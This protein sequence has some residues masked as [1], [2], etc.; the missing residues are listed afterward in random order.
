ML[1]RLLLARHGRTEWNETGRYQGSSDVGLSSGGLQEAEAL[2]RRLAGERIDAIYCSDLKRAV[3][4]AE[5]VARGRDLKL[6][7]H[8]ELREIDFGGLEGLTFGEIDRRYPGI[9]WW[10][11]RDPDMKLPQ[12]ES[13]SQLAKRVRRFLAELGGH[14]DEETAL[15]VA[16]GGTLRAV[17][18][19]VL[20]LS[21][22]HWWQISIDSASLSMIDRYSTTSVLSHLN[23]VCHLEHLKDVGP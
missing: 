1:N 21:L 15:V 2:G 4:T 16:H 18:C 13:V 19:L 3:E 10:T 17:I 9:D 6:I 12:G 5:A 14:S 11:A 22:E 8:K 20:G 7:T 23:D